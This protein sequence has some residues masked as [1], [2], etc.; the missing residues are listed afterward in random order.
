VGGGRSGGEFENATGC[1]WA[2]AEKGRKMEGPSTP[3][4][5]GGRSRG[6]QRLE[7]RAFYFLI[8]WACESPL[9]L[10]EE[11]RLGHANL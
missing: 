3:P 5:A 6:C 8:S 7:L 2:W 9:P 10:E 11:S 1:A 4:A